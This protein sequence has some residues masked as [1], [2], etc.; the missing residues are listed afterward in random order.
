MSTQ[1]LDKVINAI[2]VSIDS[3]NPE[4]VELIADLYKAIELI[5]EVTA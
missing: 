1:E 3:T 5:E 4:E 2:K